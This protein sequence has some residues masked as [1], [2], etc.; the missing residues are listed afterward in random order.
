MT[1]DASHTINEYCS[2]EKVSR[3]KLYD[4][5]KKGRGPRYFLGAGSHR[6]ISEEARREYRRGLEAEAAQTAAAEAT[7]AA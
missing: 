6:R 7:Q 3:A 1:D 2:L 5:W 4:E